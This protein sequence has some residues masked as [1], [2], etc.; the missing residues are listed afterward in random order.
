MAPPPKRVPPHFEVF[1]ADRDAAMGKLAVDR[2]NEYAN[3]MAWAM[4]FSERSKRWRSQAIRLP[5]GTV[6]VEMINARDQ[7][8]HAIEWTTKPPRE[9]HYAFFDRAMAVELAWF[10]YGF[11]RPW[12]IDDE[13]LAKLVDEPPVS[14]AQ[15]FGE[16]FSMQICVGVRRAYAVLSAACL[17]E[18]PEG[19]DVALKELFETMSEECKRYDARAELAIFE[20]AGLLELPTSEAGFDDESKRWHWMLLDYTRALDPGLYEAISDLLKRIAKNEEGV[21][22]CWGA[23]VHR[24]SVDACVGVLLSRAVACDPAHDGKQLAGF[25]DPMSTRAAGSFGWWCSWLAHMIGEDEAVGDRLADEKIGMFMHYAWEE[26]GKREPE[27]RDA[28]A[29]AFPAMF[30]PP[31]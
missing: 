14:H 20:L 2:P 11:Y 9:P 5:P 31:S 7:L 23:L 22:D 16:L 18:P 29:R 4:T 19:G 21:S 28:L 8:V 30:I 3:H 13:R 6:L 12:E 24:Q 25:T 26:L 15:I 27:L 1:Q 17:D 10:V